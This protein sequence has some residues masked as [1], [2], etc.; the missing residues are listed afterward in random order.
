[1]SESDVKFIREVAIADSPA[2]FKPYHE[3]LVRG[4]S[5]PHR[6]RKK[7]EA[8]SNATP[9]RLAQVDG[10]IAEMGEDLHTSIEEGF[11]PSSTPCAQEI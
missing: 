8:S 7:L 5:L 6:A 2:R 11:N 4:F 3:R 9:E 1:M 10:V